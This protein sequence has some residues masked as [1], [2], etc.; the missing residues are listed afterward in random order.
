M[1][2]LGPNGAGKSTTFGMLSMAFPRSQGEI[3]VFDSSIENVNL[4]KY[5]QFIGMCP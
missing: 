2:L 5:G 3:N 1:G 4:S